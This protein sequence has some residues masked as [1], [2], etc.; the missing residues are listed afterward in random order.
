MTKHLKKGKVHTHVMNR[1]GVFA[2]VRLGDCREILPT[3]P[4]PFEFI[5]ADP[6]FNIGQAYNGYDD[7]QAYADYQVMLFQSIQACASKLTNTGILALHGP[8]DLVQPFMIAAN[9]A[10]LIRIGWVN[11]HYRFGQCNRNNWIDA[12][13]HCLIYAKNPAVYTWNPEEVLVQSD[14]ASTYGDKRINDTENGGMRLPGT[15]WGVPS[16]GPYWGRVQG[17]SKERR[18]GHPNQLP[19]VYLERLIRAYTNPGDR[20]LDPF[21][22]SGTTAVV[23]SALGR[24]VTTI[25]ISEANCESISKRLEKGAIRVPR[26]DAKK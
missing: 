17:N 15:V 12:R 22:G 25:D 24:H 20:I 2:A 23:A 9:H 3:I 4:T 5:F 13:C 1:N 26:K 19:E 16:D 14:R 10:N 21:G 6:P 7:G 11:W 18:K 8:D